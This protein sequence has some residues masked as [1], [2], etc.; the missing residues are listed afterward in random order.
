MKVWRMTPSGLSPQVGP[1]QARPPLGTRAHS[2][3]AQQRRLRSSPAACAGRQGEKGVVHYGAL[4]DPRDDQME[5][6]GDIHGE[7]V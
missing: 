3:G 5:K 7:G 6:I 1:P 4:R 2:R